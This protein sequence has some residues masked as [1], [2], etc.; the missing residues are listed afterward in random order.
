MKVK[1]GPYRRRFNRKIKIHIDDYDT[2]N[3]EHTLALITLPLLKRYK[4]VSH[5]FFFIE[6]EDVPEELRTG[7]ENIWEES[8]S[9]AEEAK[10][11]WIIDQLIWT[12][13]Q[14][15]DD[16]WED[17]YFHGDPEFDFVPHVDA[18]GEETGYTELKSKDNFS[19]D[20]EGLSSHNRRIDEGLRLF[21]KYYRNLWN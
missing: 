13:E 4:K 6:D 16:S 15:V 1:I 11:E 17:Q 21:G 18:N 19:I 9:D 5:G 8:D 7:L 2:W 3:A 10:Y 12:F 20:M 14:L